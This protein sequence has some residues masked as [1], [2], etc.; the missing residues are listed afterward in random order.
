[1]S[2]YTK[3]Q[4]P[5]Q[6]I[7]TGPDGVAL[8]SVDAIDHGMWQLTHPTRGISTRASRDGAEQLAEQYLRGRK[9]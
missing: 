7:Y 2:Q 8:A 6:T 5:D 4:T 3:T 1:M 9:S